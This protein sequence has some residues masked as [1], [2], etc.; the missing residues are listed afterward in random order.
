MR[1]AL[2]RDARGIVENLLNDR[3]LIPDAQP[4]RP[5]EII[6]ENRPRQVHTLFGVIGLRR[7]YYH[8][9]KARTGRY[10]LDHALDL[11]RGH[12]PGLARLICRA[13]SQGGSYDEAAQDLHACLGLNLEGRNF[14]RL[15]A[16]ATPLLRQAQAA[17]PAAAAEPIPILYVAS[18]GTGVPLRRGELHG[19]AGKEPDGTARTREAK[20]G[21]VFTQTSTDEEGQPL[22]A[23]D[24]TT[25][26]G[27][28]EDCRQLGALLRAE[29]LRRG[30]ARARTTVYLGDGAAWIWENARLNFPDAVQILDFYHA[31]EHAGALAAALLGAGPPAKEQQSR[32]C[33][34]MKETSSAP[35][36]AHAQA[37]REERRAH[38]APEQ[39]QTIERETAYFQTNAERT[40]YGYFRKQGY[41]I[42][43][44]T[45]LRA[46]GSGV[47]EAGC[48]TVV[49]RR[50]KQSGMFW[51]QRGGDDLL[52]LRCMIL[53]PNFSQIW[54]ARLPILQAQRAKPPRWSPSL[55]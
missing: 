36:I 52:T 10:P 27:T 2:F 44:S 33:H 4:V 43:P 6:H 25:Y 31:S 35:I 42:G 37:L 38:L 9:T 55:N 45:A 24:S 15:V 3:S 41:F 5:L 48:K 22:R 7:R 11:V 46:F 8:H 47:V 21:C 19:V 18:D 40:R 49:G 39:L 54:N 30:C 12:T 28:L 23:P 1:D 53:G 13:S 16:E 34:Q 17:L 29:A 14:G 50:R 51:S 32:W 26:V 20:L